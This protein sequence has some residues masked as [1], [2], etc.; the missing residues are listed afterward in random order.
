MADEITDII[1]KEQFVICIRWV[2][3]DLNANEDFIGLHELSVTNA[4]TLAFILKDVVLRLGLDPE[5]LRGQCY[6]GCSTMMGKKSGVAPAIKNELNRNALA[7][8]CHAHAL[9]LGGGDNIK[10]SKLM[11][12]A[13]ETSLEISKLAKK[14]PKRESQLITIHTKGL[15]TENDE[16]NKTKTIRVFSKTRWTVRCGAL[17]S[18]IQHYKELKELWKWCLIKNTNE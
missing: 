17:V 16:Q 5:R 1:D 13:L 14:S 6:D 3:N 18:I 8:H 11:Q 15:F 7:I 12:N 2:D 10:N 4:E 9:N